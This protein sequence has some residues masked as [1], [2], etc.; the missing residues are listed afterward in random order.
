M[1]STKNFI[2]EN[3]EEYI[4]A[5]TQRKRNQIE[6]RGLN[7]QRKAIMDHYLL[8]LEPHDNQLK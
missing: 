1:S 6:L 4:Q 7:L 5:K 8:D 2:A 3:K